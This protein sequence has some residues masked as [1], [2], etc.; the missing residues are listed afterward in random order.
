[1]SPGWPALQQAFLCGDKIAPTGDFAYPVWLRKIAALSITLTRLLFI[2][3]FGG[4]RFPRITHR[5]R[6]S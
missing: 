1:M 6:T 2:G 4:S 3:R 5:D